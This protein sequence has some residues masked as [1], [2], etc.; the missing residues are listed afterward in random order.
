MRAPPMKHPTAAPAI[1]PASPPALFEEDVEVG[2]ALAAEDTTGVTDV[3]VATLPS[4]LVVVITN[5]DVDVVGVLL[6][7]ETV[8]A[9]LVAEERVDT[10]KVFRSVTPSR[11]WVEMD[12]NSVSSWS[13]PGSSWI[14]VVKP[15]VVPPP[16]PCRFFIIASNAIFA[17]HCKYGKVVGEDAE[18]KIN[19]AKDHAAAH[20]GGADPVKARDHGVWS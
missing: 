15:A 7:A 5:E 12:N 8:P 19:P 3:D 9:L 14:V 10:V 4:E 2:V 13:V 1:A 17:Q 20:E 6:I 16:P 18:C 11:V